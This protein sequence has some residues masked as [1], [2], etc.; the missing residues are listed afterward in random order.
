[1]GYVHPGRESYGS[2][3]K[4]SVRRSRDRHVFRGARLPPSSGTS[5]KGW[6]EAT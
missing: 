3:M 6:S 1:M 5:T 2:A 4:L